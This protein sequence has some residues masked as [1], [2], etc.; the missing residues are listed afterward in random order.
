MDYSLAFLST[1]S[2]VN[3]IDGPPRYLYEV[4]GLSYI[5][6]LI[7]PHVQSI[8]EKINWHASLKQKVA[9]NTHIVHYVIS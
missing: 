3:G 7:M 5:F 4:A 9:I 2:H 1:N 8:I 6:L